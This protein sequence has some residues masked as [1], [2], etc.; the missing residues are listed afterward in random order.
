MNVKGDKQDAEKGGGRGG[1]GSSKVVGWVGGEVRLVK[2]WRVA[3]K[4]CASEQFPYATEPGL[5]SALEE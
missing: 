3:E 2:G 1:C 4:I 5:P